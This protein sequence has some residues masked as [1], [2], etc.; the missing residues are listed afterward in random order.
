MAFLPW[1]RDCAERVIGAPTFRLA[2][3]DDTRETAISVFQN[4]TCPPRASPP[5]L[6]L[7]GIG[8]PA[9]SSHEGYDISEPARRGWRNKGWSNK[10]PPDVTGGCANR[11]MGKPVRGVIHVTP[12]RDAMWYSVGLICPGLTS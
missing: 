2:G 11:N 6:K 12:C 7:P 8:T 4:A 10:V 9:G 3:I 5:P 1:R